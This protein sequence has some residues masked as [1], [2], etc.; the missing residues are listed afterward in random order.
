MVTNH[1]PTNGKDTRRILNE[2]HTITYFPHSAG[3]EIKY[4][5]EEYVGLD[6]KQ[7]AYMKKRCSRWCTVFKNYPPSLYA[8]ERDRATEHYG[9]GRAVYFFFSAGA[10]AGAGAGF[11]ALFFARSSSLRWKCRLKLG[12][13]FGS[14]SC[15][16]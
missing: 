13:V 16:T 11:P 4:M 10:G 1:L 8:P 2:A 14:V 6:K 7:I 15:R 12:R 5:L 9:R 3:G